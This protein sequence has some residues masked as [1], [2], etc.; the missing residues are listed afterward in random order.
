VPS[1]SKV[2]NRVNGHQHKPK[3]VNEV[4]KKAEAL[5]DNRDYSFLLSDDADLSS[6]PKEK[7]AAR[8][9]FSQKADR[10]VMHSASKSKAPTS[11]PAQLSNGYGSKNTLSTQRHAEGRVDSMRR[12]AL[13]NRERVV[14]RDS[15]RMHSIVRNGSNQASNSKIT[16]QKLPTKGPIAN[17]H[18]SKDLNDPA[19]RKGSVASRHEIDRPKS[20]QSQRMQSAGQRPQ[21]SSHGQRPQ[22]SVQQRPQ[23]SLPNRRLQQVSQGQR[24]QQSLQSQRPQQS[25]HVQK[26]QSSQTHRPQMQS[27]RSQSMQVQRSLSSQGQYSEQRRV[28]ANDRVKQVER[29]IRPPSKPM[30]SRPLSSN[31]IRDDHAKRK[32]VV[33][34][35]FDEDEDEEDPLAMIRN[36]F[37]YDPRKYA[38]RDEDD[39][40]ME[41]DFAT[42]EREEKRR[43]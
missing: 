26:L 23:Q 2:Q 29:Q 42:I 28:Q 12:E 41:A 4:K 17:R 40:D 20:S 10:E 37:G 15:E 13:S 3:I 25:S 32:Q 27:N 24:P 38:G 16:S 14:S 11:Q 19:L 6:S 35:R 43:Y 33:K 31:G 22:Q 7:S 18:L 30:P 21:L 1:S 34:R 5:K 9:S 36:M 39:S 8:S